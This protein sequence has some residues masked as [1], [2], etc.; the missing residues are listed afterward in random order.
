[1]DVAAM[2]AGTV[3]TD[4]Y[5]PF[6][7]P[8]APFCAWQYQ[9]G[10]LPADQPVRMHLDLSASADAGHTQPVTDP[11]PANNTADIWVKRECS[12]L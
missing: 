12:C 6:A 5:T 1:M 4:G 11:S 7:A 10:N 9:P 3:Q 8:P 2:T